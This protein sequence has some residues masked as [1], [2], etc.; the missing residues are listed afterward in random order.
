MD[1][2]AT[3]EASRKFLFPHHPRAGALLAAQPVRLAVLMSAFSAII[4]FVPAWRLN[5]LSIPGEKCCVC[6]APEFAPK[7]DGSQARSSA[8]PQRPCPAGE[9]RSCR[10]N[11]NVGIWYRQN[12]SVM[13]LVVFP[14][15][16][17]MVAAVCR[18]I[19]PAVQKI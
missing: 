6:V 19:R 5:L 11:E 16:L 13:Y 7:A 4:M 1:L 18:K 17:A 2:L 9:V 8:E 3:D 10:S 12:W 15:V 14:V